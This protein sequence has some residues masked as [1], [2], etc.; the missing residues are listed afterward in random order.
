MT[1]EAFG[2]GRRK[3]QQVFVGPERGVW[4]A[5]GLVVGGWLGAAAEKECMGTQPELEGRAV[6]G[7]VR[8][9]ELFAQNFQGLR[10]DCFRVA[11]RGSHEAMAHFGQHFFV[12]GGHLA[13]RGYQ[14]CCS[15]VQVDGERQW[16][17]GETFAK[18]AAYRQRPC[19]QQVDAAMELVATDFRA[20]EFVEVADERSQLQICV[21]G[22][23]CGEPVEDWGRAIGMGGV[24][25]AHCLRYFEARQLL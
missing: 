7:K 18:Q 9:S 24:G 2:L 3:C 14:T 10:T 11:A 21:G 19:V 23:F 12:A 8:N 20:P 13:K 22:K 16:S 17:A 5:A 15:A 6:A 25:D 4:N 1:A